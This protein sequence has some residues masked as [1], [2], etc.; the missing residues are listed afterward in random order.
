MGIF[1]RLSLNRKGGEMTSE[2]FN[3]ELSQAE[4]N[5]LCHAA[6]C[7]FFALIQQESIQTGME[8]ILPWHLSP[9]SR[10]PPPSSLDESLVT[11][12]VSMLLRLG[13]V[14]RDSEDNIRIVLNRQH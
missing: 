4:A 8:I 1:L 10:L 12:A 5:R 2:Q 14:A 11:E 9:P 13:I 3:P 6:S 7:V